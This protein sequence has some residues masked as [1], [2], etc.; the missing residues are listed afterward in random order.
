MKSGRHNVK[1]ATETSAISTRPNRMK[2]SS[3]ILNRRQFLRSTTA[4]GMAAY[5]HQ[6]LPVFAQNVAE[7]PVVKPDSTGAIELVI[8]ETE[9]VIGGKSAW[10]TTLNGS[11][12]GPLVRLREG[13]EAVIRVTN[14]LKGDSSIHWHGVILP[15]QMDGVPGLSYD[16]IQP[17]E[18]FE[19][20]FPVTQNGTYWYHSHTGL[21]EQ[22]GLYGPMII[23]AARREPWGYDRDYVVMLS[24][25]T[26]DDP[27]TLLG[28]LKKQA[29]YSNY[30]QRT[31]LEFIRDTRR[32]GF[33]PT[34]KERLMW[35]KMRM[36]PT[37]FAD[38]TGHY[39]TYLM[40]GRDPDSNWTGLF[41]PG[42]KV[43]LRFINAAAG[44]YFDVRIPGL[45]LTVVQADG[46]NVSPVQVDEFRIAIAETYDVIVEPKADQA[47][48]I[49]AESM[50]RSGYA[51]G[52]LAPRAGLSAAIPPRRERPTLTMKDMGMD[53]GDRKG[54]SGM[55]GMKSMDSMNG[56]TGMKAMPKRD[57][58]MPKMEHAK[59]GTTPPSPPQSHGPAT[60][61]MQHGG[62]GAAK[63]YKHGSDSHGPGN[64]SV[65][66]AS[67]SRLHEPGSGLEDSPWKV[68]VY[69]DLKSPAPGLD[70][71]EPR[72]EIEMHLTGNMQRYMWSFDG[73][74]FSGGTEPIRLVHGERVRLT[75]VNDTMMNHPIHLHGM[76]LVLDN[77]NG[78]HNPR[79]H[80]INVKPAERLSADVTVDA[81][82]NW[83][84]HCHILFHMEM[85]MFRVVSVS[86]PVK[87]GKG[88]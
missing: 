66:M 56:M 75:F 73:E 49:F 29:D 71:R 84:F 87:E 2:H 23:E 67:Q 60:T 19:Y 21:Q 30:Q 70:Q 51:R 16:G 46:Q 25:W 17:R 57:A 72:R 26:F 6:L 28:K 68:L 77:G 45:P 48:T 8:D 61:G 18:T 54:M 52:T 4:L 35:S 9:I 63:P 58:A 59:M 79:K 40:N 34:M 85:G 83:A 36:M 31:L 12:P 13:T 78:Q 20:R 88:A 41:K 5:A 15:H 80:T 37:D 43:R 69:T 24:D 74:S 86:K 53:M 55:D 1:K 14:R 32:D 64:T 44:T 76:W 27:H 22:T 10:T 81:P 39:Y 47:Y 82:G 11:V 3:P 33:V 62:E 7:R 42:E 50:D 65:A 38:I